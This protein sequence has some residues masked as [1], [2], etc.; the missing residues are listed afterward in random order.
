MADIKIKVEGRIATNL[1]PEVKLVTK[2]DGYTVEFEFDETWSVSSLKTALFIANGHCI[3]VPFVGNVCNVPMLVG[4]ELLN[5]GVKS[6][7]VL[8]LQTTTAAKVL[9]VLSAD[10]LVVDEIPAPSQSVYDQLVSMINEGMVKG[11]KGDKGDKG[12]KGDAGSIKFIPVTK[13][14]EKTDPTIDQSAIYVEPLENPDE[15]NKYGEYIFVNG[16]WEKLGEITIEVDHS[17]YVKFTD[18]AGINKYG[19]FSI[20]PVVRGV[21]VDMD[22]YIYISAADK[23]AIDQKSNP[24]APIVPAFGDYFIKKGITTNTETW[25]D[26][27]KE[28]ACETIGALRL[29]SDTSKSRVAY[30]VNE[31][32]G[33]EMMPIRVTTDTPYSLVRRSGLQIKTV[34]P[35]EEDDVP[36]KKY[37]DGLIA[38]LRAEIEALKNG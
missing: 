1:T 10:D 37:V 6:D 3:P 25:T 5:V 18:Y 36:N 29:S 9:C 14:P 26:E 38:E 35:E 2:N 11:D 24:Y 28:K 16:D 22:G 8:G 33:Q 17:E 32:G 30:T 15:K 20:G 4:V 23:S 7:D 34:I 21:F 12:E 31:Q 19:I 13:L 27:E